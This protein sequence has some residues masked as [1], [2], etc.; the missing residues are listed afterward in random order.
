MATDGESVYFRTMDETY[1][2][3]VAGGAASLLGKTFGNLGGP[4]WVIG[5]KLVSQATGQPVF[6]AMPKTGGSWTTLQDA[7]SDKRAG[8]GAAQAIVGNAR[9][10]QPESAQRALFDGAYFYWIGEDVSGGG[11][12]SRAMRTWAIRRAAP[13]G[14][15]PETLFKSGV[16]LA[17]LV[18][19]G[20]RLLFAESDQPENAASQ[21]KV[22]PNGSG[23]EIPI[24]GPRA[25]SLW[26]MPAGGGAPEL[27][28]RPFPR[29]MLGV[30]VVSDGASLYYGDSVGLEFGLYR[31][32]VAGDAAPELVDPKVLLVYWGA[33]YDSDRV[34]LFVSRPDLTGAAFETTRQVITAPRG[35]SRFE[36]ARCIDPSLE[37]HAFVMSHKT[38]FVSLNDSKEGTSGVVKIALP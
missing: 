11:I 8:A 24:P 33:P 7:R 3:P 16:E 38:L 14:G 9:Q 23:Q 22:S 36:V 20:D 1:R 13:S 17:G 4:S 35:S 34:A 21:G 12:G 29:A 31:L 27:R 5:D 28:K 2:V 15:V 25:W 37:A 32:S 19:A 6:L 26:S 10:G 18:K 30:A